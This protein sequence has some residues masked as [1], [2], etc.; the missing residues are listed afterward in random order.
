VG[1][2]DPLPPGRRVEEISHLGKEGYSKPGALDFP[3]ARGK[4]WSKDAPTS[5]TGEF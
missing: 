1:L 3:D 2:W 4:P 5:S